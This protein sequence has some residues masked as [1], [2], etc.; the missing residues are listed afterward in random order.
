VQSLTDVPDRELVERLILREDEWAFRLLH[1]RHTPRLTR[2]AGTLTADNT[3]DRDELVQDT[4]VRAVARL[5]SFQWRASL[6]TWLTGILVNLFR[7]A[8]RARGQTKF[9]ELSEEMAV[10]PAP[11]DITDRMELERAIAALAPGHRT[12]LV[13][14]DVEGFTHQEIAELLGIAVGTSK[15]QLCR[16]RRAVVHTLNSERKNERY[17]G[18]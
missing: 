2:L 9:I 13:L 4:W 3:I 5:S 6:I 11:P 12:I 14:H 15:S 18:T 1:Q 7:E 17:A 10:W 8:L 16:A